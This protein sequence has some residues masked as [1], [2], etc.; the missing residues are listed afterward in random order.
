MHY[1]K[2]KT[3]IKNNTTSFVGGSW[4]QD[5]KGYT[6][7]TIGIMNDVNKKHLSINIIKIF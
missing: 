7:N 3:Q 5:I 2:Q 6:L 1:N 4:E